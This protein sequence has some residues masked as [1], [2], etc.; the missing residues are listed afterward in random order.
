MTPSEKKK[1]MQL[2]QAANA[3]SNREPGAVAEWRRLVREVGVPL[4]GIKKGM[5][6]WA[7]PR[8]IVLERPFR[9]MLGTGTQK[10]PKKK[11]LTRRTAEARAKVAV[12]VA[13]LEGRVDV[14]SRAI[15]LMDLQTAELRKMRDDLRAKGRTLAQKK[16]RRK[17]RKRTTKRRAA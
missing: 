17:S 1:V 15:A 2:I 4:M 7:T 10:A 13:Q 12:E 6:A 8:G 9:E 16:R 3:M 5:P 14:E 11:A